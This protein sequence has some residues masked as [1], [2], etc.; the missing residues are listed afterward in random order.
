MLI[1][2]FK[3]VG[4]PLDC[5]RHTTSMQANSKDVAWVLVISRI[6]SMKKSAEIPKQ[7][8]ENAQAKTPPAKTLAPTVRGY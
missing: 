4:C 5:S 7:Y 6:A 2:L 8:A 3:S 1:R